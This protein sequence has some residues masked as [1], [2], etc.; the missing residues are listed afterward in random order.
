MRGFPL[1]SPN[2]GAMSEWLRSWFQVILELHTSR[3][4]PGFDPQSHQ[5]GFSSVHIVQFLALVL[6]HVELR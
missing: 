5:G 6:L 1:K 2:F 4:W 3:N